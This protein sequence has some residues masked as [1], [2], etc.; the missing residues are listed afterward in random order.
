MPNSQSYWWSAPSAVWRYGM[1]AFT[2]IFAIVAGLAVE[3]LLQTNPTVSLFVCGIMFAAWFGGV[4][5][6]LLAAVLS[7]VAFDHYFVMPANSVL[8]STRDIQRLLLFAAAALFAVLL[9]AEQRQTARHL[10][11]ARDE[12]QQKV[13]ELERVNEALRDENIERKRTEKKLREA[14][15]E[16]QLIID[17]IPSMVV[18]AR[19]D[20]KTDFVNRPWV[21]Y[22]GMTLDEVE[23]MGWHNLA[24]PDDRQRGMD[25]WSRDVA[26][27]RR[28]ENELRTLRADGGYG[29]ILFRSVPLRDE[30]G[31]IINWYG[32]SIDIEARKRAENALQRSET[33]L[34]HAQRH[35][36][37]G[38]F[39]WNLANGEVAWSEETYRIMG[40][41]FNVKPTTDIILGSVHPDDRE[42]ARRQIERA[43]QGEWEYDYEL[44]LL[45]PDRTLKYIH[46]RAQR[47]KYESGEEEIIGAVMDVT[48]ARKAQEELNELQ[49]ELAHI[50]R[51]TTL[52]EMSTSI[53]HEVNQPLAA[54]M[55]S[56][57]AGLRW[58][59]RDLPEKEKAIAAFERIVSE[60]NRAS[61]VIRRIRDLAK[62]AEPEMARLDINNVVDDVVTL[63]RRE[64]ANKSVDLR[65]QLAAGLPLVSGDRIQ[66][67]QVLINLVINGIQAM[68]ATNGGS[69]MLAIRTQ[70]GGPQQVLVAV[71]DTGVGIAPENL[72]QLFSPFYTT[73]PDGLGMGLSI[74]RSIVEAHGGRV[75][76]S[77]NT[78]AGMTFQFSLS[79][80]GPEN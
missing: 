13:G 38:S 46:I 49:K 62:K 4:G 6:G 34:A 45:T 55:A 44:R 19:P 30:H 80:D 56:G 11:R 79:V 40:L 43:A 74:C 31:N 41:D 42:I 51:V 77:R 39:G 16:L 12:L 72:D 60:A 24:H 35:S 75:W 17:T 59:S 68:A 8:T 52:G 1:A 64:A 65:L 25:L 2:V 53:A 63:V 23:R 5:P 58:L 37:T 47:V 28:H 15:R 33:H 7:F 9:V 76:A 66:L 57:G 48:A 71:E 27:G 10:R 22:H 69:R 14:E 29:W 3:A 26:A 18:R 21:E 32:A 61:M 36:H 50:T 20:G 67:Q 73:K 54:I 78:D 70:Q